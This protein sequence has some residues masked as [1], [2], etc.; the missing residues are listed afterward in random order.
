[1]YDVIEHLQEPRRDLKFV[2][3]VLKPGGILFILCPNE[4]ALIRKL[5]KLVFHLTFSK[6]M[7]P[8][9]VLYYQD[10]LSYFTRRSLLALIKQLDLE[11]VGLE[12]R[13]QELSRLDLS[14]LQKALLQVLFFASGCLKDSGGKFVLYA[15]KPLSS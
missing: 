5:S 9:R 7:T 8:L 3:D 10:H 14:P 13:N 4:G 1:L 6:F 15:R 2:Y 12:T 11:M